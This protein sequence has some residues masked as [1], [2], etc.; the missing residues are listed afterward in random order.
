MYSTVRLLYSYE[1][2]YIPVLYWDT[3]YESTSTA[4]GVGVNV[5]NRSIVFELSKESV[6]DGA[7]EQSER[8]TR[9]P[10]KFYRCKNKANRK[11]EYSTRT[12]TGEKN[13]LINIVN[14]DNLKCIGS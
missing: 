11:I 14:M 2:E 6:A 7:T 13:E 9:I 12:S 1:Y 8:V 10:L 4:K 3:E 5:L